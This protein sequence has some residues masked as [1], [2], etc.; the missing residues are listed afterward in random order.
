MFQTSITRFKP[1][2]LSRLVDSDV[3]EAAHALA[4]TLETSA[5]GVI[6]EHTPASPVA[7]GLAAELKNTLEQIREHG[8][9]VFD[10]ECVVVL[11]AM[12]NGARSA[13]TADSASTKYLDLLGRLLQ[14]SGTGAAPAAPAP[15]A[16]SPLI[17]P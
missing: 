4:A 16:E 9:R 13:A 17:L 12:E 10:H 2:G 15:E 7:Q 5:K 11:R 8:A 14:A 6:Y 3:A 1:T